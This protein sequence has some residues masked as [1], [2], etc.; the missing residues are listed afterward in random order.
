MH[1]DEIVRS[2]DCHRVVY[3]NART[4]SIVAVKRSPGSERKSIQKAPTVM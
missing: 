3:I 2:M 4:S 1:T